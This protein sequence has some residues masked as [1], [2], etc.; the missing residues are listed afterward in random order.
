[1]EPVGVAVAVPWC[2]GWRRRSQGVMVDRWLYPLMA[3]LGVVGPGPSGGVRVRHGMT[4][5]WSRTFEFHKRTEE[6]WAH[7]GK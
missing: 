7:C 1:M 6:T 2:C 3:L 4:V 5:M